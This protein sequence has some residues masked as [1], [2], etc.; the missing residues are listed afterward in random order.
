M[1]RKWVYKAVV[2]I[3]VLIVSL[4]LV[5]F[6]TKIKIIS[7]GQTYSSKTLSLSCQ[8]VEK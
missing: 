6:K 3:L 8:H 4:Q 2:I 5:Y 1:V 7:V